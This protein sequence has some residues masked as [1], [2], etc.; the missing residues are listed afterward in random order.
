MQSFD[1]RFQASHHPFFRLYCS[2]S[3]PQSLLQYAL[4]GAA[5]ISSHQMHIPFIDLITGWRF[6]NA[7]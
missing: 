7:A 3:S 6:D 4:F 2:S 5:V 1:V